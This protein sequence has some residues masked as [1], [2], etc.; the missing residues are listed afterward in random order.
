MVISVS[1]NMF[2]GGSLPQSGPTGQPA[3]S[4]EGAEG[5]FKV[6]GWADGDIGPYREMAYYG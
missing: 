5:H 1:I 6:K 2:N 3:P 4:P